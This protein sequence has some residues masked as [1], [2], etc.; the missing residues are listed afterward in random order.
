MGSSSQLQVA[1]LAQMC[2][3]APSSAQRRPAVLSGQQQPG[4]N[5]G[6][7]PGQSP[8]QNH[9]RS[10]GRSPKAPVK[11]SVKAPVKATVKALERSSEQGTFGGSLQC[12]LNYCSVFVGPKRALSEDLVYCFFLFGF[13]NINKLNKQ[14]METNR[15]DK[16]TACLAIANSLGCWSRK[17]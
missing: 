6:Q 2:T 16:K 1:K 3:A 17:F 12:S 15:Y 4:S 8:G 13:K 11:A 5:T 7:N 10:L 14:S 9:G